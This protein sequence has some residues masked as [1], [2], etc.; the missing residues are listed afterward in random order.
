M[1]VSDLMLQSTY[2]SSINKSK[3]RLA[4]L[5]QQAAT[6]KK[7]SVPSD[8]PFGTVSI[9]SLQDR[10]VTAQ[11]YVKNMD[12]ITGFLYETENN[13]STI[14]NEISKVLTSISEARNTV[15]GNLDV[16]A[17]QIDLII[18]SL[19]DAANSQYEGKYLFGGTDYSTKPYGETTDGLSIEVKTSSIAGEQKV[20]VSQNVQQQINITG[21][22]LFSTIIKQG[23]SL[24]STAAVG[25]VVT[26]STTIYNAEG[27]QFTLN[28]S[29]EKTAANTYEMT[30]DI[31]DGTSTSIYG[32]PPDVVTLEFN[33]TNGR[34][35]SINSADPALFN[36]KDS[37]N[38]I[39]FNLDLRNFKE[40]SGTSGV[41]FSANQ[42]IDIFNRLILLRDNL[43]AG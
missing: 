33:A 43:K 6:G 24:D 10:I 18:D 8:S 14:E 38:K 35:D 3:A 20:N 31:L 9:L 42:D 41:T 28:V 17:N 11:S 40:V 15:E 1:R 2:L 34:L 5:Q 37:A 27:T 19:L 23:G 29:Y 4:D 22:D 26:G 21:A 39:D 32:T 12:N 30:Y 36:I 13:L 25:D 16:Y 7:I